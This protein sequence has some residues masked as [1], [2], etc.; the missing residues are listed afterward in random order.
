MALGIFVEDFHEYGHVSFKYNI[1]ILHKE[2]IIPP[3]SPIV[4]LNLRKQE[5]HQHFNRLY[6]STGSPLLFVLL[7]RHADNELDELITHY[8]GYWVKFGFLFREVY[9]LKVYVKISLCVASTVDD[10]DSLAKVL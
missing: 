3:L 6:L 1:D 2:A 10:F 4:I 9:G 8:A 7:E 5:V